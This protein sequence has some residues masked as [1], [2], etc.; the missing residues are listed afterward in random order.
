MSK[1][2]NNI[3]S[4]YVIGVFWFS[5]SL[6]I[7]TTNDVFA[8]FLGANLHTFQLTFL[9]FLF[10]T[11]SLLPIMLYSGK[12]SF[13]TERIIMHLFRGGLLFSAIALWCYG[14]TIVPIALA[15]TL[16]FTIPFFTLILARFFLKEKIGKSRWLATIIGFLGVSIAINPIN[17]SFSFL[18]LVLLISAA[19]FSGLDVLN[20]KFV[21]KESMLAMLFYTAL[22]TTLIGLGPAIM[23]WKPVLN[24][25]LFILILLGAGA[26]LLLFFLLKAFT[27]AEASALAPFRYVELI[28][29]GLVGFF[30]FHEIPT[31]SLCLGALIIIPTT[32]YIVREETKGEEPISVIPEA[33]K[34]TTF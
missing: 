25:E 13:K 7:S 23:V 3:S 24:H 12:D 14:L 18:T 16:N 4:S 28:F 11:L 22:F 33:E 2:K 5:L 21:S 26:N 32:I 31:F 15:T 1:S 6:V 8:K 20:K 19:M 10:G 17:T 30:I 9:R 27:Y 34:S 29:S